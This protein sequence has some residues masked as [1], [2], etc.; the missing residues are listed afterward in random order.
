MA[1]FP[2]PKDVRAWR[3]TFWLSAVLALLLVASLAPYFTSSTELVRMRNALLYEE[4]P[5]QADWTPATIPADWLLE[6]T[7]PPSMFARV[8]NDHALIAPGDDW[9]TA[10]RI[11]RHLLSGVVAHRGSGG[12]V[13]SDLSDTYGEITTRG[14]GYC[15][16]Y[17]DVFTALA[18]A[19]SVFSRA[20]AFSFGG[21]DGH[22]HIF[23]EI[24]DRKTESW[25]MIDVFN[26]YYVVDENERPLAALE[27]RRAL[28]AG[29]PIRWRAVE[30]AAR[31]GYKYPGKAVDYYRRGADEWYLWWGNNVFEYDGNPVV[32]LFSVPSRSLGQLSAIAVGVYP[33]IRVL[34][35][36]ANEAQRASL[37]ALRMHLL[38][39]AG[40]VPL[41]MLLMT[42]S[43]VRIRTLCRSTR[44]VQAAG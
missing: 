33:P 22:G 44:R 16:D 28:L 18:N 4:A 10:L 19:S 41:L 30:P 11:G 26:N 31:P 20:W 34:E 7:P 8:V 6:R 40:L 17:V 29:E 42:I 36:P 24:W 37:R 5:A 1:K 14:R 27:F 39:V 35:V 13:Q 23:N 38:V 43:T 12:P 25:R 3:A 2:S 15:G 21:F 9:E 32:S